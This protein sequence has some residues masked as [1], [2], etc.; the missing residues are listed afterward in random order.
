M[1]N[2]AKA[3]ADDCNLQKV[4]KQNKIFNKYYLKQGY[5]FMSR[6]DVY[7]SVVELLTEKN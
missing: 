5:K 3:I 7:N 1:K 4:I 6:D 2:V